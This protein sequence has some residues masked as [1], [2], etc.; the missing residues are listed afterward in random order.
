LCGERPDFTL[1]PKQRFYG[2]AQAHIL[3]P[4][5]V[6]PTANDDDEELKQLIRHMIGPGWGSFGVKRSKE[7]I[8]DYIKTVNN[9]G[10]VVSIDVGVYRDGKFNE[11]QVEVLKYIGKNI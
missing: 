9:A 11:E 5:G 6:T 7:F 4:L 3:A 1:V 8:L 10:G 2:G